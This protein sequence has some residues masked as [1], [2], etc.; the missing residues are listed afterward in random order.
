MPNTREL[1]SIA[2]PTSATCEIVGLT[3]P[4]VQAGVFVPFNV[5]ALTPGTAQLIPGT[6]ELKGVA[7]SSSTFC[8]AVGT[9]GLG[10]TAILPISFGAPGSAQ[11]IGPATE[12]DGI[13]CAGSTCE[14]VGYQSGPNV[15]HG[16][17]LQI[18]NGTPVGPFQ[19]AGSSIIDAVACPLATTCDA[20]SGDSVWTITNGIVGGA[21]S[22]AANISLA[23]IGC[24]TSAACEVTGSQSSGGPFFTGLVIPMPNGTLG[25]PEL[26]SG[27]HFLDGLACPGGNCD[28]VGQSDPVGTGVV[29]TTKA[30]PTFTNQA[31]PGGPAGQPI[32]DTAVMAGGAA[33]ERLCRV[34]AL[35]TR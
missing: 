9:S 32:Y 14:A 30:I 24:P 11:A 27:T 33:P 20:V 28:A 13:A 29:V 7:C 31:A 5:A 4:N 16:A 18:S 25:S 23:G 26:I 1:F 3:V 34:Q 2:C 22:V 17:V 15:P 21:Q 8:E 12:L 10:V 6:T 35:R 19:Y